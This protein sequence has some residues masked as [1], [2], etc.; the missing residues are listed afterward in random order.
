MSVFISD[1]QNIWNNAEC[2]SLMELV[3]SNVVAQSAWIYNFN[4]DMISQNYRVSGLRPS[5][6]ILETRKH[7]SE[8]F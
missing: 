4:T 1:D 6:G 8:T 2:C 5:S 7:N 3:T